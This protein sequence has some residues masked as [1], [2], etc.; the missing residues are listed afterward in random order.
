[1][2][3]LKIRFSISR[4]SN[5]KKLRRESFEKVLIMLCWLVDGGLLRGSWIKRF[6]HV[7]ILLF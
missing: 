3:Q 1:M 6:L 4:R 5:C 7:A 2:H